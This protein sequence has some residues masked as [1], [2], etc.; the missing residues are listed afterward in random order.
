[1]KRNDAEIKHC[2]TDDMIADCFTKPNQG[3]KFRKFS[4]GIM[5]LCES[6]GQPECVGG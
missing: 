4:K 3:G 2:P 5:N 1:M 6:V